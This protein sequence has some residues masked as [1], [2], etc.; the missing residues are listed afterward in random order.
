V[1]VEEYKHETAERQ[2][3]RRIMA[4]LTG[5]A[6]WAGKH[7]PSRSSQQN[8]PPAAPAP[9]RRIR[10]IGQIFAILALVFLFGA[11]GLL[12][13]LDRTFAGHIYPNISINGI[14]VGQMTETT[15]SNILHERYAPFLE[16]PI[17]LTYGE[18]TWTPDLEELGVRLELDPAVQEALDAGR[19]NGLM[20]NLFQVAAVWENG[21]DVPLHLTV[22]Q[23]AMQAY[24]LARAV[25][26]E[27]E[28]INA[29]L[30]LRGTRIQTS[31]ATNG[32]QALVH[33]TMQ[34]LTAA[35][36]TLEPQTVV[37]RTR[38]IA[39]ALDNA[40]VAA[41]EREIE[42]LLQGPLTL[43][44]EEQTWEWSERELAALIT[45]NQ[46]TR[47]DNAGSQLV[48]SLDREEVRQRLEEIARNAGGEATNPR[49]DWNGGDLK[50]IEDGQAGRQVN[51]SRAEQLVLTAMTTP[52]RVVELPFHVA[53]PAITAANLD[54][55]S[56]PDLVAVGKSDFT[57]SAAYRITNIKAGMDMLHG[58]LLAP[59]EEFSFN[60]NI[61]ITAANGFVEGYAIIE[62]RTQLEW[63]GGI[64]QDSTTMFRAA[65]W[66]G[67][68]ITERHGHSFYIN[69]YDKYGYGEFGDGPGMDATIYTGPGG[70]DLKF[71]NDTGNWLLIQTHVDTART[72]AEIRFY[73]TKPNRTVELEGPP[74]HQVVNRTSPPAAPVYIADPSRPVGAPRQ[75]DVARGGMTINFT[76]IIKENGVVVDRETFVTTFKPW[77]NIFLVN[78]V[79]M[80]GYRAPAPAQPA[81]P[82]EEAPPE[83]APV[84]E[85]PPPAEQPPQ[86][87]PQPPQ[88]APQPPQPAPPAPQPQKPITPPGDVAPVPVIPP[89]DIAPITP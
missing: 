26:V 41:A 65:F 88:P 35:L 27:Q 31:H 24:L 57:G 47:S 17:Q 86:P 42:T 83:E 21:L 56:I 77:P 34:D 4:M 40:A 46:T 1:S 28:A 72:L 9:R 62:N 13:H 12:F 38:A 36:Q 3:Q 73:G 7:I 80:P 68:P 85:A 79:N 45:I 59:G 22:D 11:G 32:R 20:N 69:W 67:L 5:W 44:A 87:A 81:A 66:A 37:L 82:A 14:S 51:V 78:P 70:S 25:E 50:I 33:D 64:C 18:H 74:Y 10:L 6:E 29:E 39:P 75:T 63:G 49:I 16:Q 23:S 53:E 55:L 2:P 54:Q 52:D 60:E 48:V 61:E 43:Q 30:T 84:E 15:A 58:I 19:R 76:R 8:P 71:V 89:G